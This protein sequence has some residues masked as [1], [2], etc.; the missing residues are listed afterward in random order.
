VEDIKRLETYDPSKETTERL[1]DDWRIVHAW[2]SQIK[3]G[4]EFT[5]S[6]EQ[7][8]NVASL[9]Y[10]ELKKRGTEFHPEDYTPAGKELFGI[11]SKGKL[12]ADLED[13]AE[14]SGLILVEPHGK[15]LVDGKK[16]LMVK[17][18]RLKDIQNKPWLIIQGDEAL[19]VV[20]FGK[21]EQISLEEFE[22]LRDEHKISE[23]ERE[24]WWPEKRTFYKYK[25]L[26]V[27]RFKKP[28]KVVREKGPQV[29]IKQVK[30]ADQER[31]LA[32]ILRS[33]ERLGPAL[34]LEDV[35]PRFKDFYITKPYIY[36][37]GGLCNHPDE[38]TTG[39]IDLLIRER[40]PRGNER[41]PLVFRLYRLFP[42]EMWDRLQVLW[43]N[44]DFGPFTNFVPLYDQLIERRDDGTQVV[45]MSEEEG[46]EA[47]D[48]PEFSTDADVP[49]EIAD[50]IRSEKPEILAM[51]K[52]SKSRG[53]KPFRFFEMLKGIA[54][55]RK[56][57]KYSI[58]SVKAVTKDA[59]YP[60]EVD[61]KFDG[62]RLQ[63]HKKGDKVRIFSID[64]ANLTNRL[65]FMA[66]ELKEWPQGVVLDAEMTGWTKGFRK[67]THLGRSDVAGFIHAKGPLPHENFFANV[68]DIL[69]LDGKDMSPHP[70]AE[71]RA[72]LEKLPKAEHVRVIDMRVAKN[73][74][75]LGPAIK[76]AS[77]FPASE[78]AMIKSMK[79]TY[80]LGGQTSKWIKFV[81][82]ANIDAEVVAVHSVKGSKAKNYLSILRTARGDPIP[83]GRTYNTPIQAKI[84][85]IIRVAFVNMNQYTDPKTGKTWFNW[86]RPRVIELREDKTKPD[87]DFT[88]RRIAEETKGEK[89]EKPFPTRYK[90]VLKVDELNL[91]L[92]DYPDIELAEITRLFDLT[93]DEIL[94]LRGSV[95]L[96]AGSLHACSQDEPVFDVNPYLT[97]GDE[98]K[99]W[100]FAVQNHHRGRS[101]HQDLRMERPSFLVG[102]TLNVQRKGIPKEDVDTMEEARE[103]AKDPKNIKNFKQGTQG[104]QQIVAEKKAPEPFPWLNFEGVM[105]RGEVGATKEHEGVFLITASGEVEFGAAKPWFQEYWLHDTKKTYNYSGRLVVRLLK[106]IWGPERTGRGKFVWM[107]WFTKDQKPYILSKRA[108]DIKA[109]PPQGLSWLPRAMRKKVP[110]SLRYWKVKDKKKARKVRDELS[111][112]YRKG[113]IQ[114]DVDGLPKSGKFSLTHICWRGPIVVRFGCSREEHHLFLEMNGKVFDI[115]MDGN[116]IELGKVSAVRGEPKDKKWA[117]FTGRLPQESV[118]N[119]DKTTPADMKTLE[120]GTYRVISEDP[121]KLELEMK[122][123]TFKG[124]WV[125]QRTR[126]KT[127]LWVFKKAT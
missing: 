47:I 21:A 82:E 91:F 1:R 96:G 101:L 12:E 107:A 26:V 113:K 95:P 13:E 32:E 118:L 104:A 97:P 17:S 78:G 50:V 65:D 46:M 30:F 122:G 89:G 63:L 126:P 102:R 62:M 114:L 115:I 119:P 9:I 42:R 2:W 55:Y 19:G 106:N 77:A 110:E 87:T 20:M 10:A 73:K 53:I 31:D 37:V 125:F 39:D 88:A 36:L 121:D 16:T 75:E 66:D 52:E 124:R 81:K 116:P 23:E 34:T 48:Y 84:G 4:R 45:L 103:F 58:E 80:P 7:V 6:R 79:S 71:R 59:D 41:M 92:E 112:M 15:L 109:M 57:E 43:S 108:V 38:G 24:K 68:F 3:A 105:K 69:Y 76:W 127:T 54:G 22:E 8:I 56:L 85:D 49:F 98:D 86:W 5:Y 60:F 29:I 67:G 14:T 51:A 61:Q 94:E 27:Y 33:G 120:K 123:P 72:A 74:D 99:K 44:D 18:I 64:G 35:L 40:K 28:A 83:V 90:K 93:E 100:K 117:K 70:L 11:V 25:P 111:E